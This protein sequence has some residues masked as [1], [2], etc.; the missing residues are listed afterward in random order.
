ML[1]ETTEER[2]R[3]ACPGAVL[4]L[5]YKDTLMYFPCFDSV[6]FFSCMEKINKSVDICH[7][8]IRQGGTSFS[9]GTQLNH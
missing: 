7:V 1:T 8:H 9:S 2:E 6:F 4:E 3:H 5:A